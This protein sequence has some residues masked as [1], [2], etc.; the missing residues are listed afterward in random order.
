M[1]QL[2]HYLAFVSVGLSVGMCL[3]L[4]VFFAVKGWPTLSSTVLFFPL[5]PRRR[6]SEIPKS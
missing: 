2:P 6:K 3:S 1:K 5:F 4:A